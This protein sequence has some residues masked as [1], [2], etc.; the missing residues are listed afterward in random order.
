MKRRS[1]LQKASATGALALLHPACSEDEPQTAA[2]PPLRYFLHG[3]A[4][5]DP[6][7]SAVILW[8]RVSPDEEQVIEASWLVARDLG[9]SDIVASGAISTSQ[10]KD[11]C[12]KV[13]VSGLA[14]NTTYYFAFDALGERSRIG[15]TKTMPSGDVSRLRLGV[16]SCSSFPHGYFNVYRHLSKRS[17]LD[18]IVHLGDYIYEYADGSYGELRSSEP[19]NE[20][21]SLEDYRKRYAQY[22]RD[23]DLQEL[24]RQFP[25]VTVWDDHEVA[26]NAYKDGASNHDAD[27]GEFSARKQ[28]ALQAY[29]E[30]LPIRG[31]QNGKIY[32]SIPL[33]D[34]A[35]LVLLDTRI[36]GRDKQA[37]DGD[38]PSLSDPD[39]SLLGS[40]QEAWLDEQLQEH[41]SRYL[42]LGQQV[43]MGQLPQFT[44]TDAWDGYPAARERLFDELK[45]N[46]IENA[47]V[48]TGDIHTSW[49]QE[50]TYDPS[51]PDYDPATGAGSVAVEF[52]TPA[53]SSPGFPT[54]L[55]ALADSLVQE[56]PHLK[57]ADL[58]QRGYMVLDLNKERAEC[59][60]YHVDTVEVP[61]S[62]ESHSAT[63]DKRDGEPGLKSKTQPD[64]APQGPALA[65]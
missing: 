52:V 44:N 13:D 26:N 47:V 1:F 3:V 56:S 53:V 5:G 21:V 36:A 58:V 39:R 15:R 54:G 4:S 6:T 65:P 7:S 22:R 11:Y 33:G 32:R 46:Q 14:A 60:W 49:A 25:M 16:V 43:M 55:A 38:D 30:W 28:A 10:D 17:E 34:L 29:L 64:P 2:I 20:I 51:S 61:E 27:E 48:L 8:T 12:C 57:Y 63:F 24:H 9:L 50:L 18:L 62:A 37:K 35:E 23:L 59:S 41:N 45:K 40:E 31:G 19:K 42:V